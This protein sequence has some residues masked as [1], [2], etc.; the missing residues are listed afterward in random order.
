MLQ[1][2]PW[3]WPGSVPDFIKRNFKLVITLV[4]ENFDVP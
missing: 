1:C 4:T 3:R 2:G